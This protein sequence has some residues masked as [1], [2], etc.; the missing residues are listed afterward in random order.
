DRI[1]ILN[2]ATGE[3]NTLDLS[4]LFDQTV[5]LKND[6]TLAS[7]PVGTSHEYFS[8]ASLNRGFT[9]YTP[10]TQIQEKDGRV[11]WQLKGNT[12]STGSA[13]PSEPGSDNE[14]PV[15]PPGDAG[16]GQGNAMV[17]DK[18]DNATGTTVNGNTLF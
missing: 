13:I 4:S 8:F 5:T 16:T 12:D 1:D 10:D 14:Q 18:N 15:T 7:A 3:H 9:V 6:L 2:K 17:G 11:F